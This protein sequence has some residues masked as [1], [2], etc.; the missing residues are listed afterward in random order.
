MQEVYRNVIVIRLTRLEQSVDS[1][2][3]LVYPSSG[4]PDRYNRVESSLA[5]IGDHSVLV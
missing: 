5:V 4:R 2:Q 3:H 1:G